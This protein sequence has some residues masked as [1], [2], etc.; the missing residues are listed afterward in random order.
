MLKQELIPTVPIE[1]RVTSSWK[2][3][4]LATEA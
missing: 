1:I 3:G 2:N 4:Y